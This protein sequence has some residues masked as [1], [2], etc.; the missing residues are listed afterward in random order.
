MT[1]RNYRTK[2]WRGSSSAC[3]PSPTRSTDITVHSDF[4][5]SHRA[6]SCILIVN[7]TATAPTTCP[8][9][10]HRSDVHTAL[11]AKRSWPIK[12]VTQIRVSSPIRRGFRP[13]LTSVAIATAN[14][15]AHPCI[16]RLVIR[17]LMRQAGHWV[18]CNRSGKEEFDIAVQLANSSISHERR[19]AADIL[20]HQ[21][22]MGRA[23]LNCV[24]S[25]R[26]LRPDLVRATRRGSRVFPAI[27]R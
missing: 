2:P 20:G 7:V 4:D 9:P 15:G 11:N 23:S 14:R 12:L 24:E 6:A 27:C 25:G 19:V 3:S 1:Q 18:L 16:R 13:P 22:G 26:H 21:A 8:N 5:S 17:N 10:I